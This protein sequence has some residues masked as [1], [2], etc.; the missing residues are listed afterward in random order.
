MNSQYHIAKIIGT[1]NCDFEDIDESQI[2]ESV[3]TEGWM[4]SFPSWVDSNKDKI[5]AKY[6]ELLNDPQKADEE[7]DRL[8]VHF[9]ISK[10]EISTLQEKVT[11]TMEKDGRHAWLKN[12]IRGTFG[13]H[14]TIGTVL[15]AILL[16]IGRLVLWSVLF[17]SLGKGV[18]AMFLTHYWSNR[19]VS[20][21]VRK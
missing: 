14:V 12:L 10:S 4:D 2:A 1:R 5:L 8:R 17:G 6:Q 3:L 9:G 19:T 20:R 11:T 13:E 21:V 16:E 18:V 15:L 7:A